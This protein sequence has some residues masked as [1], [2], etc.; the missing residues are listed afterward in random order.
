M[1]PRPQAVNLVRV[2][3]GDT[4]VVK[5]RGLLAFLKSTKRLRLYGIDAPESDQKGGKQATDHLKKLMGRGSNIRMIAID[6]D[7]YKRTVAIIYHRSKSAAESYN[8]DMVY[9]GHARWYRQYGAGPYGFQKAENYAKS[10]KLG[11][12]SYNAQAP[13]DY[14][15][16]LREH[17]TTGRKLRWIFLGLATLAIVAAIVTYSIGMPA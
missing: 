9:A 4:V 2:I 15:R 10:N 8:R 1:P 5:P 6:R 16:Q 7:H 11:I 14:R 3:D 17:T 12:W 13:W